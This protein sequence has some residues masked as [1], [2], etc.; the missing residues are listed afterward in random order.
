MEYVK[1]KTENCDYFDTIH[2]V[3]KRCKQYYYLFNETKCEKIG[4]N[5]CTYGTPE[6]CTN[7]EASY[8]VFDP[9]TC[10]EIGISHC[11]VGTPTEC[12]G[13]DDGY[14]LK[15]K[16]ECDKEQD[17]CIVFDLLKKKMFKLRRI[18]LCIQ[19]SKM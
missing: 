17:H 6:N 4:I 1:K 13:C 7:C 18:L 8:Y 10:K 11:R 16:T 15:N 19:R 2:G 5:H 14:Y 3:C 9:K 12:K